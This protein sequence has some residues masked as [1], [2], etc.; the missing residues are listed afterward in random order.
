[1][2]MSTNGRTQILQNTGLAIIALGVAVTG[3]A[4]GSS[5]LIPLAIAILLWNLLEALISS[6]ERIGLGDH[7]LPRSVAMILGIVVVILSLYL[8]ISILF[9]QADAIQAAWPRYVNRLEAMVGELTQ[10][11]G[12]LGSEKVRK[13]FQ[14]IDLTRR[15]P[16]LLFS[17]QSFMVSLAL[18]IAYVGFLLA[19]GQH[20]K[21]KVAAMFQSKEQAAKT[22]ALLSDI[23]DSIRGYIWIKTLV[24]LLTGGV[25]YTI[26]RLIG[27]DFAETWAILI[28][29][30]NFIPN[31]GSILAVTFPALI[32]LVQFDSLS[33]FVTLVLGLTAIQFAVGNILEPILMGSTLNMSPFAIILGLAFWGTIWGIVGMFLSVPILVLVTIVCAHIP[34]WRWIAI[35]LSRDGQIGM[36]RAS[37]PVD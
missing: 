14:Q 28:F 29:V 31:I 18:V 27:V 13:L 17:A 34:S 8:V 10:W 35:L 32:A 25:S 6:F 23:S 1:M 2:T 19:E 15:I 20:L 36:S 37:R 24:S 22:T 11:L 30:L 33:P 26:M 16:S 7:R 12:P 9:G 21:A 3:L 5:F 4:L